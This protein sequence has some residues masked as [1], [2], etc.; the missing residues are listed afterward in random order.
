MCIVFSPEQ[1]IAVR[2]LN[3][4]V[5]ISHNGSM[6]TLLLVV[7]VKIQYTR[8]DEPTISCIN[9]DKNIDN[10]VYFVCIE[11]SNLLILLS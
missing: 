1:P 6:K 3:Y 7:L 8:D 10:E 4:P 9:Q 2:W 5:V 11:F